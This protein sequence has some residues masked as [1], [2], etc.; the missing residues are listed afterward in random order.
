[1]ATSHELVISEVFDERLIELF[2]IADEKVHEDKDYAAAKRALKE[3][4]GI[5]SDLAQY[6]D[7]LMNGETPDN[8]KGKFVADYFSDYDYK[9]RKP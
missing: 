3:L 8:K 9:R 2:S 4:S 7:Y 6:Y 5:A 1:M